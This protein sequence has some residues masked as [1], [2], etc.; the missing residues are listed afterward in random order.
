MLIMQTQQTRKNQ[1]HYRFE[2]HLNT[3]YCHQIIILQKLKQYRLKIKSK[4]LV[5]SEFASLK[6]L[7]F[8]D[9]I[10]LITLQMPTSVS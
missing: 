10:L 6:K 1:S 7:S 3:Y 5:I 4:S 8:L 9:N 2:Q